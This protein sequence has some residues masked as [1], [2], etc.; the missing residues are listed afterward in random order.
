MSVMCHLKSSHI[1]KVVTVPH[2]EK[3]R[4]SVMFTFLCFLHSFFEVNISDVIY[5]VASKLFVEEG[6]KI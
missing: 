5:C 1:F 4:N 3:Y 6:F 2:L